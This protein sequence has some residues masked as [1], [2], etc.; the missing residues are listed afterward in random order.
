MPPPLPVP[1]VHPGIPRK[2]PLTS[3]LEYRP[4]PHPEVMEL[5]VVMVLG[6]SPA[7]SG[8][9]L[10]TRKCKATSSSPKSIARLLEQVFVPVVFVEYRVIVRG[11]RRSGCSG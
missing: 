4:P 8:F 5:Q 9:R 1:P 2:S 3:N 7:F 6:P 10:K 11:E